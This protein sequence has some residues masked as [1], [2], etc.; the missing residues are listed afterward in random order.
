[1]TTHPDW[2]H[3]RQHLPSEAAWKEHFPLS[4]GWQREIT[5]IRQY[6]EPYTREDAWLD[7]LERLPSKEQVQRL[8][9]LL[10]ITELREIAQGVIIDCAAGCKAGDLLEVAQ[11]IN[12]WAATA[13]EI[14]SS[15]KRLRFILAARQRKTT[16]GT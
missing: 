4:A 12:N 11:T 15:R 7:Q 6:V 16:S 1:M 8:L 14:A 5:Q 10:R 3:T 2:H 9:A 13:E